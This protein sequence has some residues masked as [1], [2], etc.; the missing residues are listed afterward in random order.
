MA[1]SG[2]QNSYGGGNVNSIS[3]GGGNSASKELV[4]QSSTFYEKTD[5]K[6]NIDLLYNKFMVKMETKILG[7]MDKFYDS[8]GG[9][10]YQLAEHSELS[11]D[12]VTIINNNTWNTN[13]NKNMALYSKAINGIYASSIYYEQCETNLKDKDREIEYYTS[14]RKLIMSAESALEEVAT[15]R[16]EIET[17]IQLYGVPNN[18]VFD[19]I[20]LGN[21]LLAL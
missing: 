21:I 10:D 6:I 13:F 18:L 15:I 11:I 1:F 16:P 2:S 17:Y 4:G 3:F 8:S 5:N 12:L 19:S 14:D 9:V 20:K 7:Y